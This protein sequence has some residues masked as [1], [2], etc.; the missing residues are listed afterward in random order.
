MKKNVELIKSYWNDRAGNDGSQQSTTM[1]IWL[2]DI[3]SK[4]VSESIQIYQPNYVCDIG[5]GDGRTT[6][7]AALSYPDVFFFGF[8][9][10]ENMIKNANENKKKYELENIEFAVGDAT[11]HIESKKFDFV[12]STRCLINLADWAD[13]KNALNN[14]KDS[15]KPGGAYLMI[16]NFIEGH[17]L[18]NS[19]RSSFAL[20]AIP[21][22]DHNTFFNKDLLLDFMSSIFRIES[23]IN[24]SSTYYMVSR[25]IYSS[26]CQQDQ[27]IP[28]YSDIHHELASKLPF[29]GEYGPV[30][31]ITFIRY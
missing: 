24:I 10:S 21:I 30:R 31:A 22:R 27:L 29:L 15:L 19:L 12:F 20:P 9:Y 23:D 7:K 6:I 3:E 1:D 4:V 26:I 28:D 17:E 11:N 13:Q 18:F 16:E 25:I 14:I 8:D 5:C 2:R